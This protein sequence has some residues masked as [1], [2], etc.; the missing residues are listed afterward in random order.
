MEPMNAGCARL[1]GGEAPAGSA[2]VLV[3]LMRLTLLSTVILA[4]CDSG[5]AA[6]ADSPDCT[7]I[8]SSIERLACFDAA[9]GT[10]PSAPVRQRPVAPDMT[11]AR[12]STDI[13]QRVKANEAGRRPE[14]TA[15]RIT[16]R[17]DT[18]L[19][20]DKVVISA[21]ALGGAAPHTYLAI[22]CLS[23]ISR[24]QL[25]SPEPLPVNHITVRFL[26]DGRAMTARPWQVLEDGTVSDAG[27][28]LVAIEQ[29]RLLARPGSLLQIESDHAPFDDMRFDA[30]ALSAQIARQR[31]ACHW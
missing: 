9:A 8:I 24:L 23:N 21:P 16:H 4:G 27:R 31:E 10:P 7:R 13:A 11:E 15:S 28:G 22:S 17:A 6:M 30:S 12:Q 14:E 3:K 26:L 2:G 1:H 5:K 18:L 19:G 29:L 20:Q 25:L